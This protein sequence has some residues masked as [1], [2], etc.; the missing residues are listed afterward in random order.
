MNPDSS[1]PIFP[2]WFFK[3][4][5]LFDKLAVWIEKTFFESSYS[6]TPEKLMVVALC[7]NIFGLHRVYAGRKIGAV[8]GWLLLLFSLVAR[9][10][11]LWF[12]LPWF[13]IELIRIALGNYG[14]VKTN[15]K[16]DFNNLRELL[17][18]KTSGI[19]KAIFAGVSVLVLVMILAFA[20][21]TD[22]NAESAVV[23]GSDAVSGSEITISATDTTTATKA[24]TSKTKRSKRTTST[25][26]T[27]TSTSKAKDE[28][29]LDLSDAVGGTA[30]DIDGLQLYFGEL[31][32]INYAGDGV[33]VVKAKIKSS[34]SNK[35]TVDQNYYSV[36][37][38]IRDNGFD[39]CKEI[40]YWAVAD[41]RD[42]S[43]QKVIIFSVNSRTIKRVFNG[44]I[45]DNQLGEYV[46]DLWL[47][48]SLR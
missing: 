30:I 17:L 25:R 33:V 35:A 12:L 27:T 42:G 45:V 7:T 9:E 16:I 18:N 34:Y 37:H 13:V 29:K 8:V 39:Q 31:L 38:L 19:Y 46:D 10:Y 40:Q 3:E 28:Y 21:R 32:G 6:P 23:S 11:M 26:K 4:N 44:G 22:L 47:H 15:Q 2:Q 1:K 24:T 36:C 14:R 43:E 41:M 20:P 5:S 48:N